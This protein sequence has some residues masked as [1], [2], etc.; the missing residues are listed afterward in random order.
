MLDTN[1]CQLL[2][3]KKPT[4]SVLPKRYT[5]FIAKANESCIS[6]LLV[7]SFAILLSI[8]T[9]CWYL[10]KYSFVDFTAP[11]PVSHRRFLPSLRD[12]TFSDT[13]LKRHTSPRRL[14][15]RKHFTP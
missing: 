3:E 6:K 9:F 12:D 11:S 5:F 15:S 8:A 7:A 2:L 14:V 1:D 13:V 10:E 4:A